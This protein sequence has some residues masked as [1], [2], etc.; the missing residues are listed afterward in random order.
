MESPKHFVKFLSF[1]VAGSG[2][3]IMMTLLIASYYFAGD[4]SGR[5]ESRAFRRYFWF[6]FFVGGFLSILGCLSAGAVIQ[7]KAAIHGGLWAMGVSLAMLLFTVMGMFNIHDWPGGVAMSMFPA[8]FF[9][10]AALS[11]V[12]GLRLVWMKLHS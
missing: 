10:G 3:A 4:F 7:I 1:A 5:Y 2:L 8:T 12:G 11:L 6:I 9:A